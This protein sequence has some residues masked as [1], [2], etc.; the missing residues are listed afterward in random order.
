MMMLEGSASSCSH[1]SRTQPS[2][3][4]GGV[5]VCAAVTQQASLQLPPQ[6]C[7]EWEQQPKVRKRSFGFN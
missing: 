7:L 6:Q 4:A 2:L 3:T 5:T 1:W